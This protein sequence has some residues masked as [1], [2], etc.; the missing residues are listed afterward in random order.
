MEELGAAGF[1]EGLGGEVE[2]GGEGEGGA[3]G[4]EDF[5]E[6]VG[7]DGAGGFAGDLEDVAE[8]L[9]FVVAVTGGGVDGGDEE[10]GSGGECT[11]GV[12]L[13]LLEGDGD[14]VAEGGGVDEVPVDFDGAAGEVGVGVALFAVALGVFHVRVVRGEV[15]GGHEGGDLIPVGGGDEEIDVDER[16]GGMGGCRDV[17]QRWG[18]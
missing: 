11:G 18:L 6:P 7:V 10:E 12:L 3:G 17:G 2:A 15:E 9:E 16:G 5:L 4:G 8:V 13:E 14:A 1:V